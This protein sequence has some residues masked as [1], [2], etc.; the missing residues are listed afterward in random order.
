MKTAS[1]ITSVTNASVR[2]IENWVGRLEL[3]TPYQKTTPGRA[4][5]YSRR[6][7]LEIAFIAAMVRGGASPARAALLSA[8]S[9]REWYVF[10]AGELDR[11]IEID[12]PD[13]CALAGKFGATTLSLVRL[14]E[15]VRRVDE[16]Y[17]DD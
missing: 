1:Q 13:L 10:P 14:K 6:N 17:E 4:R 15:I 5:L 16:L 12:K 7:A 9:L 2:D 3:S 8:R 11:A